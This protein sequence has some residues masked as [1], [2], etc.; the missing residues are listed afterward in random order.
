MGFERFTL[1]FL[2]VYVLG[3]VWVSLEIRRRCRTP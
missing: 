2:I 1:L 3:Y